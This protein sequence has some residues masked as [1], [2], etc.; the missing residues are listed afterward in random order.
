MRTS[1]SEATEARINSKSQIV[2][3]GQLEM[4]MLREVV[5]GVLLVLVCSKIDVSWEI[6]NWHDTTVW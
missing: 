1:P 5:R 3:F 6:K 4:T 2:W